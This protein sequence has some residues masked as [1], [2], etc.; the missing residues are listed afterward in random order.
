PAGQAPAARKL[1]PARLPAPRRQP[2]RHAGNAWQ[3]ARLARG[4]RVAAPKRQR[5]RLRE[6]SR[7]LVLGVAPPGQGEPGGTCC[8]RARG[9]PGDKAVGSA[10]FR[11]AFPFPQLVASFRFELAVLPFCPVICTFALGVKEQR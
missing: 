3:G 10:Y 9:T 4:R 11:R 6:G 5:P 1:P 8:R 7:S 2:P